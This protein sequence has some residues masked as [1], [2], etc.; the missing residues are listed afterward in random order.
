[1]KDIYAPTV[2]EVL[3]RIVLDWLEMKHDETEKQKQEY[4]RFKA[5]ATKST[6][7]GTPE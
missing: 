7:P 2:P 4:R 1:M 5:E 6:K 3:R